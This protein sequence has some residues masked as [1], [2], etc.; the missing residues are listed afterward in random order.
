MPYTQTMQMR[1]DDIEQNPHMIAFYSRKNCKWCR[2][3]G[4]TVTSIPNGAGGWV[5]QSRICECV[6]KSIR[7]E[8]KEQDDG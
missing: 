6:K 2:G 8:L 7:K 5:N 3:R 1:L 4:R